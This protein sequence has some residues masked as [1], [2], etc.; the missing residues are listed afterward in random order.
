MIKAVVVVRN[1]EPKVVEIEDNLDSYMRVLSENLTAGELLK[2]PV[3]GLDFFGV[4]IERIG[5]IVEE[6]SA[7]H[8]YERNREWHGPALFTQIG[9]MGETI[10][11][12]DE[13]IEILKERFALANKPKSTSD[14]I[15]EFI[16]ENTPEPEIFNV[17]HECHHGVLNTHDY[18]DMLLNETR[19]DAIKEIEQV[20]DDVTTKALAENRPIK[21]VFNEYLKDLGKH[22]FIMNAVNNVFFV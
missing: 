21:E 14:K 16:K 1:E 11:M 6:Y 10:S 15:N 20:I 7:C 18:I 5:G 4:G 17:D 2:S 13:H 8:P 12:D 3:K 22:I 9:D 19:E